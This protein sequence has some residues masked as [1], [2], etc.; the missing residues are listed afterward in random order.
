MNGRTGAPPAEPRTKG[1]YL[2]LSDPEGTAMLGRAL[3][4]ADFTVEGI[5]KVLGIEAFEII[6]FC[7]LPGVVKA[8]SP[9]NPLSTLLPFFL[10]GVPMKADALARIL[11]PLTVERLESLGLVR[12]GP[13]GVMALVR[14]RPY[15]GRI[16]AAD[17]RY[18]D[19][20]A[21]PHDYVLEVNPTSDHLANITPRRRV[22]TALDV[23]CG[24]GVLAVLAAA[25]CDKV[26]ATDIN[27]RALNFTAFNAQLNGVRN[28]ECVEGSLLDPVAGRTFDLI[29]SNPPFVISPDSA[30]QFRDSGWP[31]DSMCR[32]LVRRI[33]GHLA[34]GGLAVILCNWALRKGEEWAARPTEWV[35]GLACDTIVFRTQ[36]HPAVGYA[37]SWNR[38]LA[39]AQPEAYVA[40]LDRWIAYYAK[41]GI[42]SIAGG[43]IL[44]RRRTTPEN[45]AYAVDGAVSRTPRSGDHLLRLIDAQDW[46]QAGAGPEEFARA[47]FRPAA[48]LRLEQSLAFRDGRMVPAQMSAGLAEGFKFQIDVDP[49]AW[50]AIALCDGRHSLQ[51]ILDKIGRELE[52]A[53]DFRP[54]I[55]ALF[56][57]LVAGGFITRT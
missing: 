49:I 15:E 3:V 23:G 57:S 27:P 14:L 6:P 9:Q 8:M 29:M 43:R 54:R 56:R 12:P 51:E 5:R 21:I 53:G 18:N 16:F 40:A 42:E 11:D 45:W 44:L 48:D 46:F 17:R 39:E 7:D 24:C 30:L 22:G 36:T 4:A 28:I 10:F 37:A 41:E 47:T 55:L 20:G 32:E 25:H 13:D 34:E 31:L 38:G 35:T 26:V 2:S 52:L 19:T 1:H 50:N 33:P